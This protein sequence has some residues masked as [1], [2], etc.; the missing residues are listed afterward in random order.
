MNLWICFKQRWLAL[1]GVVLLSACAV[2]NGSNLQPDISTLPQVLATMGKPAMVWKNPDGSE[3]LAFPHG[4]AGTQTFMAYIAPDGKLQ[5][6]E[7]V[8]NNGQFDRIEAGMSKEDVLR[9]LGPSG[10]YWTATYKWSSSAACGFAAISRP[11]RL[12][13]LV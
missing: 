12:W 2:P 5:R 13:P 1:A 9:R 3:Q 7:G 10:A 8:L 6:I 4:P 11:L